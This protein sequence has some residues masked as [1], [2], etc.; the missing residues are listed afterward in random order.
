[1]TTHASGFSHRTLL[2]MQRR[3]QDA[4]SARDL[5]GIRYYYTGDAH[6]LFPNGTIIVGREPISHYVKNEL[7]LG[8]IFDL[9]IHFETLQGRPHLDTFV[10]MTRKMCVCTTPPGIVSKTLIDLTLIPSGDG[11]PTIF[12]EVRIG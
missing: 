5:P 12:R 6:L 8:H 4:I 1:M 3:F 2:D 9:E 7:L 11:H 10:R